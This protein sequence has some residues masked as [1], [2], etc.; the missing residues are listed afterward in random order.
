MQA[1]IIDTHIHL[2]DEL[3]DPDRCAVIERARNASVTSMVIPAVHA[4]KWDD[5]ADLARTHTDVFAT[6][7]L[8]PLYT[9]RHHPQDLQLL[10]TRLGQQPVVAVGECGLDYYLPDTDRALQQHYF[11]EQL[12]I[13]SQFQLPVIIHARK[14]VEE[15]ILLLRSH[16]P[17]KGVIHS[18]NGSLQQAHRLIDLGYHLGFGGP[19]SYPR[20]NKLR[21]LVSSLPM[22][23]LLLETDAPFQPVH[24]QSASRNEPAN[25]QQVLSAVAQLKHSSA[26]EI[27]ERANHNACE[28]FA[29]PPA[30]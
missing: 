13:A 22:Q 8:H 19:I 3:F 2:D 28:L 17:G 30:R 20:A 24:N 1:P 23:H 14:A 5:I 26:D 15:I 29:L 16:G 11:V 9:D 4:A 18:Y 12:D 27:A 10:E 6:F 21:K 25:I 7:G